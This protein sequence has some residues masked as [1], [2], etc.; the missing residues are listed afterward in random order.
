MGVGVVRVSRHMDDAECPPFYANS[1]GISGRITRWQDIEF[2]PPCLY[3]LHS[4]VAPQGHY[5]P[6]GY[7]PGRDA[8]GD[9]GAFHTEIVYALTPETAHSVHDFWM[10]ARDFALED[11]EV[12]DYL[13]ENNHTVVMQDVHALHLVE[14]VI[15]QEERVSGTVPELSIAIDTGALAARRLMKKLTG[16]A[17]EQVVP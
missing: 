16:P 10:V 5:P 2:A 1:T 14:E 17:A 7:V 8:A 6:E 9:P 11:P 4:R 12:T 13:Y 3:R 15:A